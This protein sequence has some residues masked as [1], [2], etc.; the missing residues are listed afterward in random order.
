MK[1]SLPFFWRVDFPPVMLIL[2][3]AC[4]AWA[5]PEF[6]R[7]YL[8][9]ELGLIELATA[10]L[11]LMAA[12]LALRAARLARR[13]LPRR[14]WAWFGLVALG[15]VYIGGEELSWGQQLVHWETPPAVE[16]LN[17]QRETNL[18]NMS[19]WFN[20]KPRILVELGVLIGGVLL[21]LV[22]VLRRRPLSREQGFAYW[23]W[24][25]GELLLTA[26]LAI[27]VLV[28]KR[29]ETATGVPML[30]VNVRWSELQEFYFALFLWLHA[31]SLLAHLRTPG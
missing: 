4:K 12:V 26:A 28:P 16:A 29:Y 7:T 19:S 24:P 11:A 30:P 9:R 13:Q 20:E 1:A 3:L 22:R 17:R 25:S 6:Y 8:E 31:R 27:L 23:L 5:P 14:Q 2:V 15:C 21:P 10:L 18:H